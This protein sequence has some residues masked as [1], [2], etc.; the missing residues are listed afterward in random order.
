MAIDIEREWTAVNAAP[1]LFLGAAIV[2]G[3][4]IWLVL[5][6]LYRHRIDG[7]KEDIERLRHRLGEGSKTPP[8]D[9]Q[10]ESGEQ[11]DRSEQAPRPPASVRAKVTQGNAEN[12]EG[13]EWDDVADLTP[14]QVET[15]MA[16]CSL[17]TVAGLRVLAEHGP[18]IRASLLDRAGIENYGHFQG[19]IT[20]R[21]RTVTGNRRAF[22]VTWDDWE[23]EENAGIGHYAIT[24]KTYRSLRIYFNLD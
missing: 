23:S 15:F 4:L 19:R 2:M 7:L 22:L 12:A 17:K 11:L 24:A 13:F 1:T 18:V 3:G 10:E 8:P 16:G 5:H 20:T 21:V 9:N 6:F 14:G